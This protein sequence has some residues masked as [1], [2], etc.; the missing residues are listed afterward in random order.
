[1]CV[2]VCVCVRA[3]SRPDSITNVAGWQ[4]CTCSP[5]TRGR[6][7]RVSTIAGNR[8]VL[9][10]VWG[11]WC[12]GKLWW[13]LIALLMCQSFVWLVRTSF[14]QKGD[15]KEDTHW[16]ISEVFFRISGV[17]PP[18]L[19]SP[20]LSLSA[21]SLSVFLIQVWG[22]VYLEGAFSG[23]SIY[24]SGAKVEING[25]LGPPGPRVEQVEKES[26]RGQNWQFFDFLK[27]Y[28]TLFPLFRPP[29]REAP[30]THFR[31]FFRLWA[32]RAQMT[33]VTDKE[34]RKS[35][36]SSAASLNSCGICGSVCECCCDFPP[37]P[38][39][40]GL[41]ELSPNSASL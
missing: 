35:R 8:K 31:I 36:V 6:C 5:L 33:P 2:R 28:L 9:H 23:I 27:Y 34:D 7:L 22:Q 37:P 41:A 24:P 39:G 18:E 1:M 21:F 38:P 15:V 14:I 29:D 25:F 16:T 32:Q 26:K 3:G 20:A 11:G 30:G 19:T 17:E 10:Y 13:V 40:K 4:F 12:P